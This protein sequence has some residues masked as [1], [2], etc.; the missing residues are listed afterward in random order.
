[1]TQTLI[2]NAGGKKDWRRGADGIGRLTLDMDRGVGYV[3]NP[4]TQFK[5]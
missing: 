5:T 4:T 2:Q 1:M 3:Q